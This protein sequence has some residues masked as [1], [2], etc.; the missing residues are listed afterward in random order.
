MDFQL[1]ELYVE[2]LKEEII[3]DE[4]NP[5]F[6]WKL[7]SERRNVLQTGYRIRVGSQYGGS[8]MWDSGEVSSDISCGVVYGGRELRPCTEYF[9]RVEV[10]NNFG[11]RAARETCFETALLCEDF[12]AW[13]GAVFIGAPEYYVCSEA[14]G[15]FCLESEMTIEGS[16]CAGILF[17]AD[18]YRLENRELNEMLIE[19]E[20]Y[21]AVCIRQTAAEGGQTLALLEVWRRGYAAEDRE[22]VPLDVVPL[23]GLAMDGTYKLKLDVTGNC[24]DIHVNGVSV[25]HVQL[26]PLGDN[27]VTTFPHLGNIGYVARERTKVRFDGIRCRYIRR[28][29]KVFYACDTE[30]GIEIHAARDVLIKRKPD[31]HALPMLRRNFKA[32]G[33]VKKARLY[34]T[35]RGIY[36]CRINGREVSDIYFAP[37][38]SQFDKHLYYQ[39]YDVTDHI[40]EGDNGIGFTLSSGWWS[41][42]QT[43]VMGCYN[44]WGDRE[45][46]MAKLVITYED[47]AEDRIVTDAV[48]WDYYGE[49]A[50]KF[51]GFFQG[52]RV[53][54]RQLAQYE[55]FSMA[56]F[57]CD[58][59]KKPAVIVPD[60]IPQWDALPGFFR[61]YPDMNNTVPRLTGRTHCPV[62]AVEAFTA[63][64]VT[65]PAR[66]VYIY[67]LGQEI[68][69]T[70]RITFRGKAGETAVIRYGE[71]LYPDMAQYGGLSG[72]LLVANLRD[73]ASTD[74]YILNGAGDE[75]YS[76]RFTFHGFRYIEIS[77]VENP[78]DVTQ[79]KGVL[80]SSIPRITGSVETDQPLLN[81]FIRNVKYSQLCNFISIPTDCPQ[82]NERMGWAGDAHVFCRTA[83]QNADLKEFYLR[84]LEALRDCQEED[85]NLPEIAPVGGGFGGITYGSAMA[86]IVGELYDFYADSRIV[87]EYYPAM[88]KYMEYLSTLELPGSAY[89]GPIDDWLAP[90]KT[91][92]SLVWN[93]FYGRD[94]LLMARF[95]EVLGLTRDSERFRK[96]AGEAREY[97]GRTFFDSNKGVTLNLDGTESD[98]MGSYAIALA[99]GMLDGEDAEKAKRRLAEKAR[100]AEYRITTGFFGTGLVSAMLSEG[101]FGTEAYRMLT[102]T[103][104]PGWL[105]PVT[106]GATTI[107][108]RWDS[109]TD[110]KGFGGMNA[111]NSFNHYSLGSV[112]SW[113]YEYALGIRHGDG[114]AGWKKFLIKPDFRGFGRISGG[115]DTPYGRIESGYEITEGKVRFTCE[116]PV[117]TEAEIILP[118]GKEKVGSG[119]YTFEW[120]EEWERSLLDK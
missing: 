110:E 92:S 117:N 82:R 97:F 55:R 20:N 57:I 45:S 107:W 13:D 39:V 100:L 77:G 65:S 26:N 87:R 111:M 36:E 22:D 120:R 8:D 103:R 69:G 48:K 44:L 67:D 37:G 84:Y 83:N 93:A 62:R 27:D 114:R 59:L 66:G 79:V 115:F 108:E 17:G 12:S 46:V 68:A 31:C 119:R 30:E 116:I 40:H 33:R 86:F 25:R 113:L 23:P 49:G 99:Y 105:Y 29:S 78:P 28:P 18:D 101:G 112:L 71:M 109:F 21:V 63:V 102:Q 5:A 64:G 7:S 88:R 54:G 98:T 10:E 90:E 2:G 106:Q 43:F 95:A 11:E 58:G 75:I 14:L 9:V 61:K 89:V 19:G 41:G 76:P 51:A 35:A 85:G 24:V 60:R 91:D 53:D 70:A 3:I 42:S 74:K 52:E 6:A 1:Y 118:T 80:L 81:R 47:G 38:A 56:D 32:A 15:V 104:C 94:C 72:R 73:A 4:I 96:L 16:G 50:Y 34:A